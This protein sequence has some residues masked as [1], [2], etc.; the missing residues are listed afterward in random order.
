[1]IVGVG[2]PGYAGIIQG[3]VDGT[4]D[5]WARPPADWQAGPPAA[6]A[7]VP[8][9]GVQQADARHRRDRLPVPARRPASGP[10]VRS[11]PHRDPAP[12]AGLQAA[13]A[14]ADSVQ[15]EQRVAQSARQTKPPILITWSFTTLSQV[16]RLR[17]KP[18]YRGLPA[19]AR[20]YDAD[21]RLGLGEESVRR[22]D[23]PVRKLAL[24]DVNQAAPGEWRNLGL[25]DQGQP[26]VARFDSSTAYTPVV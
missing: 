3:P 25:G 23:V 11:L 16:A 6:G 10:L 4:A 2:G 20:P 12:A 18:N 1:M 13:V 8:D 9:V 17:R 24:V 7:L 22:R 21:L 14:G 5:Q 26:E 19:A 15:D